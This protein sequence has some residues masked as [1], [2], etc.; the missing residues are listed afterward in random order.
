[1]QTCRK[2]YA[3]LPKETIGNVEN[4]LAD[5]SKL[6]VKKNMPICRK[7]PVCRL[8]PR[9]SK[10][11]PICRKAYSVVLKYA[12]HCRNYPAV[13]ESEWDYP[14]IVETAEGFFPLLSKAFPNLPKT[15]STLSKPSPYL[16]KISPYLS[17]ADF[18]FYCVLGCYMIMHRPIY[19]YL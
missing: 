15:F 6:Q 17:K 11:S 16:S 1:M 9:L 8:S 4:E 2:E 7:S 13:V 10:N 5:L 19:F 12:R 3:I 14:G 18:V